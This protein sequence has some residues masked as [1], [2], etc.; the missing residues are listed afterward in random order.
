MA[1]P[2]N[3]LKLSGPVLLARHHDAGAFCCGN[4]ALDLWIK[5]YARQYARKDM[6]RT[7]VVCDAGANDIRAYYALA[8]GQINPGEVGAEFYK[9]LPRHPVP[10]VV[11]TRLAVD[12]SLKG[13][14]VGAALLKDALGRAVAASDAIGGRVLVVHAIDAQAKAFY[15]RFGFVELPD[16]DG[17]GL[18]LY[19]RISDIR[20]SIREAARQSDA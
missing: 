13:Q 6:G 14:G 4:E 17:A 1:D 11:L 18:H 7:F 10:A 8:P 5:R 15:Q 3:A 9:G 19:L 2:E 16:A 20:A 12:N